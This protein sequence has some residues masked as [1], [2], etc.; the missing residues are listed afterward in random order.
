[1]VATV[2]APSREPSPAAAQIEAAISDAAS[3]RGVK[4]CS[5]ERRRSLL[6][7]VT[8]QPRFM[9]NNEHASERSLH[10]NSEI[11]E[12]M[13]RKLKVALAT[14]VRA[15]ARMDAAVKSKTPMLMTFL[16]A[17]I[18]IIIGIF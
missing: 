7:P 18:I 11:R 4:L 6:A 8:V 2:G 10:R 5:N 17:V 16:F 9:S 13:M 3:D 12:N 14:A 1:V 15:R